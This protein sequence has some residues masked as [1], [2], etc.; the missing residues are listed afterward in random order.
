MSRSC[1]DRTEF[2]VNLERPRYIYIFIHRIDRYAVICS[3]GSRPAT[4]F[5]PTCTVNVLVEIVW[6]FA[7]NYSFHDRR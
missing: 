2:Y 5:R 1:A 6:F 4:M 7:T 3:S